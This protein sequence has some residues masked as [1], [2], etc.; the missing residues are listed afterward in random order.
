MNHFQTKTG[1]FAKQ[2]Q[3]KPSSDSAR[4]G[5]TPIDLSQAELR[6]IVLAI[7]G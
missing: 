5:V 7:L 2:S 1:D 6:D 4:P 3:A